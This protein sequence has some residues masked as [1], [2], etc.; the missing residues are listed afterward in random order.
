MDK[1]QL[2]GRVYKTISL[3]EADKRLKNNP[4]DLE[5]LI[6]NVESLTTYAFGFDEELID[7]VRKLF[8][9]EKS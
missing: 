2:A 3:A 9:G 7:D 6:L 8:K 4:K 5:A 1:P